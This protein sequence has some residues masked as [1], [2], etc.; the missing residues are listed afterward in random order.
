M[1]LYPPFY[2]PPAP[3]YAQ[4]IEYEFLLGSTQ[5]RVELGLLLMQFLAAAVVGAIA[6]VV[7][8]DK[9]SN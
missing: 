2:Q 8:A 3:G 4:H 6:F 7:C 1:M 5:G 9:R